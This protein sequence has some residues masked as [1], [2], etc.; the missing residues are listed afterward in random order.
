VPEQLAAQLLGPW[1]AAA[2]VP[3]AGC[4]SV[5]APRTRTIA[6]SSSGNLRFS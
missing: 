1:S 5:P 3:D 4:G 6:W 2:H